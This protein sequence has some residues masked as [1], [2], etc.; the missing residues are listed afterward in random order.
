MNDHDAVERYLDDLFDE[1]AGT[2]GA[3]RRSLAEAEDH[4]QTARDALID[5][6]VDDVTAAHEAVAR[7]GEASRIAHD[8]RV[9]HRD[10]GGLARQLVGGAW[11]LGAVGL[12]AIGLSG[13]L[14]E[15]MG[16]LWGARFVA[17][18]TD[19]VTYTAARCADFQE[20][21]PGHSCAGAAALHH[22]G[23]VVD[24]R[25]A[26]GVLGLMALGGYVLAR[27]VGPMRGGRWR[28][29][30]GPLTLVAVSLFGL[31]AVGLGGPSLLELVLGGTAGVGA[32]L[33]AGVVAGVV[34]VAAGVVGLR[35]RLSR[36]V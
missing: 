18:D 9:V 29:A 21:F 27:R 19:G 15:L 10:L 8:L 35:F 23:E 6:G 17:G 13:G 32:N 26:A 31:A 3:G 11:L 25:V 20:Y 7:F 2:G 33:S 1:L 24:Y 36:A 28:P 5:R 22:W 4:L 16:R 34:A 12:V 30:P 14:A